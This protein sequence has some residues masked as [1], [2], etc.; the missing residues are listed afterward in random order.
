MY[1]PDGA[2]TNNEVDQLNQ[3]VQTALEQTELQ[4]TKGGKN[5]CVDEANYSRPSRLSGS[6][7]NTTN[8]QQDQGNDDAKYYMNSNRTGTNEPDDQPKR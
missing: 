7:R 5:T 6:K 1:D 3:P 4:E 2:D 8:D